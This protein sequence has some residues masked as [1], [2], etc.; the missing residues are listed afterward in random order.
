MVLNMTWAQKLLPVILVKTVSVREMEEKFVSSRIV[1]HLIQ[2]VTLLKDF[3][4]DLNV[5]KSSQF[6]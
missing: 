5:Q 6:G 4:V 2:V 1:F 3:A